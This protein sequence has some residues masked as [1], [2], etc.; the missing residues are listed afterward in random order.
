MS[1][2]PADCWV[3]LT[4][5]FSCSQD[6]AVGVT[7][8][9]GMS[10]VRFRADE[11]F[12]G[13]CTGLAAVGSDFLRTTRRS[14]RNRRRLQGWGRTVMFAIS[15]QCMY[16]V[17][18][19]QTRGSRGQAYNCPPKHACST[20]TRE[21]SVFALQIVVRFLTWSFPGSQAGAAVFSNLGG[22][23]SVGFWARVSIRG[24]RTGLAAVG[25]DVWCITGQAVRNRR[26]LP[27]R[28]YD[29]YVCNRQSVY[30]HRTIHAYIRQPWTRRE[31]SQKKRMYGAHT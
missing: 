5:S 31:T 9:P 20:P 23:S 19:T 16:I 24:E 21:E 15:T 26:C 1:V 2:W 22:I 18:A 14:F 30:A 11:S 28:G 25:S 29:G 8:L 27:R 12:R 10:V 6:G 7:N 17:R 3:F 13:E 4:G